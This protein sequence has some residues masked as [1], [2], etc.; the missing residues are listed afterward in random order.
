MKAII[1]SAFVI[2]A[3]G[4][5]MSQEQM[6]RTSC[7]EAYQRAA[8]LVS[9]NDATVGLQIQFTRVTPDG[10][11]Q[12]RASDPGFADMP[13]TVIEWRM[14]DSARWTVDGIPPLA[15]EVRIEDFQPDDMQTR[16]PGAKPPLDIEATVRQDPDAG[17]VI[18][19]RAV[20]TNDFGDSL[21][22][23]GVFERVFLSSP[24]MMQVSMG[25]AA[26]KAGLMSMTLEGT[27]E[28][29]FGFYG[30]FTI[31]GTPQT[32]S[33]AAFEAISQLPDGLMND[34]SRAEL[35]AFAADLPNPVGTLELS[36]A[37]ERGFGMMQFG[38]AMYSG[39]ADQLDEGADNNELEILFDGLTI[40]ANW[41]PSAQT[42]D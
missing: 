21:S 30:E 18:L 16:G 3:A 39:F 22:V 41:S 10:W 32:Q 13:F 12:F 11:C 29:P 2:L 17:L 34:A 24:S 25:S 35:T 19:E 36:V 28:N 37:S 38:A 1:P 20:L 9:P 23:S 5:A 8:D 4:S 14:E 7:Q 42:V 40:D 33:E 26:F 6:N 15:L 27:Q 31:Q